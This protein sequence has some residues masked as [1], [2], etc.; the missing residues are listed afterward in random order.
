MS[1]SSRCNG[2]DECGD[3]SDEDGCGKVTIL[4]Y[5]IVVPLEMFAEL[6]FEKLPYI[7]EFRKLCLGSVPVP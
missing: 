4:G 3:G 2:L 5:N 6:G 1:N 7:F